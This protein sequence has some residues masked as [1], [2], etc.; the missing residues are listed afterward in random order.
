MRSAFRFTFTYWNELIRS[1]LDLF[2]DKRSCVFRFVAPV[3]HHLCTLH[4][5]SICNTFVAF[6]VKI[7][8]KEGVD[9]LCI[10]HKD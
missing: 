8:V 10:I 7:N 2:G 6:Y 4:F 5:Y 1:L 9:F 3:T